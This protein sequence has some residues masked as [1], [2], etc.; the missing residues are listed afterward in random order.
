M[1]E[2]RR[3]LVKGLLGQGGFGRVY[4]AELVSAGGF[5]KEVALKVLVGGITSHPE[6][7]IRLRDEA[8][9]L[10]L[11]RHRNIVAVDDLVQL[12]EGW[13]VVMEVVHGVDLNVFVNHMLRQKTPFPARAATEVARGIARA[14]EAAYTHSPSGTPLKAIHRDIKPG[15][16]RITPEGEVKVL[17]FGIARA[18][19][20]AREAVT[21]D[22]RFGSLAYMAPERVMGDPDTAAGDI[23]A[24]GVV[25]WETLTGHPRGR[26]V[27]R[28][29]GHDRQLQQMTEGLSYRHDLD[30]SAQDALNDLL[31]AMLAFS[32][33]TRPDA[34]EVGTRLRALT[35]QLP[36][37][38]L[39]T[40]SRRV[41]PQILAVRPALKP[42]D[43]AELH[44]RS[45]QDN[46]NNTVSF[47]PGG[48]DVP[49]SPSFHA[50]TTLSP[51]NQPQPDP[52]PPSPSW[53]PWAAM[54]L[55]GVLLMAGVAWK[56]VL[57]MVG[58]PSSESVTVQ[59]TE[60]TPTEPTPT[61][62][63]PTEPTRTEPTPTPVPAETTPT[64]TPVE[65]APRESPKPPAPT[66]PPPTA[67]S[68]KP[69]SD[70][71]PASNAPRIR[72]A[73]FAVSGV[74]QVKASCGGVHGSGASSALVRD[75]PAGQC[76][77]TVT[78]SGIGTVL[79]TRLQVDVPRGYSCAV[80]DGA[81][82]CR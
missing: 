54:T 50:A 49:P 64:P 72:A 71:P 43:V 32:P 12:E 14:L 38:D 81:L 48:E 70:P 74:D 65:A 45:L 31:H 9:L 36:G 79:S 63:T 26:A 66:P 10:G 1:N 60:P 27:L 20:Q 82:A 30:E 6:A 51:N 21:G 13:G 61:E 58:R 62:P 17:D 7:A 68:S 42:A 24:L 11:L 18:E 23:Y 73:K 8:R 47:H 41:I 53:L 77:I 40:V 52:A 16:V 78:V 25:L 4:L 3:F 59:P 75:F 33:T 67:G 35:A 57:P 22:G 46:D 56:V 55:L 19:F 44:P 2:A 69:T 37:E 15:N 80:T 76:A 29:D 5:R 39:E 34:A 28:K